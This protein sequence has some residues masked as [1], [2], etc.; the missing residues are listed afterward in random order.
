MEARLVWDGSGRAPAALSGMLARG[1]G[2]AT[3]TGAR[4]QVRFKPEASTCLKLVSIEAGH[5]ELRTSRGWEHLQPGDLVLLELGDGA[6][7]RS[8]AEFQHAVAFVPRFEGRSIGRSWAAEA[9]DEPLLGLLQGW[10]RSAGLSPS[11]GW[12]AAMA[13]SQLLAD[14]LSAG[15]ASAAWIHRQSLSV[16]ALDLAAITPDGLAAKLRMSRRRLDQ[17]LAGQGLTA[18]R[19]IWTSRLQRAAGLL[20]ADA[21]ISI[22]AIAHGCGFKDSSHFSRLFRKA[23]GHAPSAWRKQVAH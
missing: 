21:R 20:R 1:F 12:T 9:V 4:L 7:L 11:S 2:V 16:V 18:S 15:P 8:D 22:T 10:R 19:L 5:A 14:R 13:M 3:V 6:E 17:L 23:Y